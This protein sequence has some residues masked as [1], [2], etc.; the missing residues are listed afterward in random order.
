MPRLTN[1]QRNNAIGRLQQGA[2]QAA[3]A[4][5]FN[6]SRAT[7]NRL[8]IR[9]NATGSVADRP[10]SGRPR[11]TTPAQDRFIRLQHLRDR[12]QTATTTAANI[13]GLRRVSSQTIRNRL[14]S[15]GI[16]ARRPVRRNILT[17]RHRAARLQWC[18]THRVRPLQDRKSVV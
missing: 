9:H 4:R 17:Q 16:F 8:W 15:Q 12:F 2:T 6:V 3:V 5:H 18:R 13:P 7:I 14:R 10:R 1:D 11:V